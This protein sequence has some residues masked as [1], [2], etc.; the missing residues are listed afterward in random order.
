[1]NTRSVKSTIQITSRSMSLAEGVVNR[2]IREMRCNTEF[3][4]LALGRLAAKKHKN[5]RKAW[6]E[7][8]HQLPNHFSFIARGITP[9][10]PEEQSISSIRQ[11]L[12]SRN[13]R[14]REV[15]DFGIYYFLERVSPKLLRLWSMSPDLEDNLLFPVLFPVCNIS[16]HALARIFYRQ[17]Q[18]T[19]FHD[20]MKEVFC[21]QSLQAITVVEL[22]RDFFK[23]DQI[24]QLWEDEAS[25]N[26][27]EIKPLEIRTK[28]SC[29]PTRS[30]IFLLR[31]P[32]DAAIEKYRARS[33]SEAFF[34]TNPDTTLTIASTWVPYEKI[35][36]DQEDFMNDIRRFW[37]QYQDVIAE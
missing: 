19:S 13:K 29:I 18:A 3:L 1:M 28:S 27:S 10:V 6:L 14:N 5:P 12:S 16:H 21:A 32:D 34:H 7:L 26:D 23:S 36:L 25:E 31:E 24:N 17:K 8:H 35:R 22:G 37:D 15:H 33:L 30:G 4:M 11:Q 20:V 9:T 2:G